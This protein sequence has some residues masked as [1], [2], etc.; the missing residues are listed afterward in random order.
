MADVSRFARHRAPEPM[1][2]A[3]ATP[4][5]RSMRTG[6]HAPQSI[7]ARLPMVVAT[8]TASTTVQAYRTVPATRATLSM[9][10]EPGARRSTTATLTMADAT[11]SAIISALDQAIARAIQTTR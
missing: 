11:R 10:M 9:L 2:L 8:K 7:T 3:P 6:K 1:S 4:I 5:T